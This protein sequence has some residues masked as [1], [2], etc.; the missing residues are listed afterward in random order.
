MRV[1]SLCGHALRRAWT[2]ISR[3]PFAPRTGESIQ[4]RTSQP[5]RAMPCTA[6]SRAASILARSLGAARE[7]ELEHRLDER[8]ELGGPGRSEAG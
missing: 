6:C 4:S 1:A 2:N 8:D 5:A 3:V 7:P